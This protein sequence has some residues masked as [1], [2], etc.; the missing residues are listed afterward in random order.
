MKKHIWN[1]S[2]DIN[3]ITHTKLINS[4]WMIA[5]L[6]KCISV[7]RT[8][9]WPHKGKKTEF[10]SPEMQMLDPKGRRDQLAH[11]GSN[12][13]GHSSRQGGR[14]PTEYRQP[15]CSRRQT[16]TAS[17]CSM[18]PRWSSSCCSWAR[19]W[20]RSTRSLEKPVWI[21]H[22]FWFGAA[23]TLRPVKWSEL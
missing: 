5:H 22:L 6:V 16:G 10:I 13:R 4:R 23:G 20:S 12:R 9:I 21:T 11:T 18:A 15:W 3:S 19:K 7:F 14:D 8:N 2:I 1:Y 17:C